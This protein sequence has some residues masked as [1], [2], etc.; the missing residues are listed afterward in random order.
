MKI[1][2][3]KDNNGNVITY[4]YRM[5]TMPQALS[6]GFILDS[7]PYHLYSHPLHGLQPS[8]LEPHGR[9]H[10]C[11]MHGV[12]RYGWQPGLDAHP[13]ALQWCAQLAGADQRGLKQMCE[14]K[15]LS[16]WR[17]QALPHVLGGSSRSSCLPCTRELQSCTSRAPWATMPGTGKL[18]IWLTVQKVWLVHSS[19]Q[20]S[21]SEC[22]H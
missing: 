12:R 6:K 21:S 18:W 17:G 9:W 15:L 5:F 7:H 16:G 19:G 14:R 2:F 1:A 3:E 10:H 11:S 22:K 4:L 13:P 20:I 8:V